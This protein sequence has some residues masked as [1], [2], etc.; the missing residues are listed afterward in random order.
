MVAGRCTVA[1]LALALAG[2]ASSSRC[3][4]DSTAYGITL[5]SGIGITVGESGLQAAFA[6]IRD[7]FDRNPTT[8]QGNMS[9][10]AEVATEAAAKNA[11]APMSDEQRRALREQAGGWVENY[12]EKCRPGS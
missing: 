6:A 7:Y 12:A 8:G 4:S 11:A 9:Q 3:P 5:P 1:V 10:A 2:C